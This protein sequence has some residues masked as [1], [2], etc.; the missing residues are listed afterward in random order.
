MKI[1]VTGRK[2]QVAHSIAQRA[3]ESGLNNISFFGQSELDLEHT[4]TIAPFIKTQA[5]DLIINTA[6]WTAVDT[7]ED[8]A[9]RAHRVNTIAPFE[10]AKAA[11]AID[12]KL[13]HISTDYVYS[14]DKPSPY[15]ETDP[16]GPNSVYGRT[17]LD[18]ETRILETLEQALILRTA[19]VY[20]PFG[21]NFVK[22]MLSLAESRDILTVVNDQYGSPTSALDL[23]DAILAIAQDWA[24]ATPRGTDKIF[25]C[26]GTG[27]THW[28][29]FAQY[30]FETSRDKGGPY[31]KVTGIP[32]SDW[33]TKAKRP[34]NS[35]LDCT[36]L[37]TVFGI[38][39]PDWKSSITGTVATILKA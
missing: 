5:P 23:A 19:W 8:E 9:E 2:G 7:A 20:S 24:S 39:L 28:A 4:H 34:Y 29:D 1:L 33:P 31:A 14:G 17:K 38:S 16:V 26:A 36:A 3:L 6:A 32:S 25:H 11:K 21:K 35:R 27:H 10:I 22:S 15:V 30:I 37:K 18:G 13:I 12:A